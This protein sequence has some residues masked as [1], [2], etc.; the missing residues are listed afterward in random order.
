[1]RRQLTVYSPL[2][3]SG[4]VGAASA[5]AFHGERE[6]RQLERELLRRFSADRVI[7]TG[8]GT[9]A[10]QLAIEATVTHRP[11]RE[12]VVALPG[13]SCFDLVSA[14][15][16]ADVAVRFYDVDPSTLT[17]DV[18]S[19]R[20]ALLGGA[21]A[22]VVG[23]LYGY[24][25]NWSELRAVSEE[26]EVP[27]IEDAAQGLGTTA[28]VGT[29]GTLGDMT[30]LSFG[31]GKG[32]TGGG[33]G[34]VLVRGERRRIDSAERRTPRS[35]RSARAALVTAVVWGLGRPHLYG[36]PTAV[37][38]LGLGETTYSDPTGP[39]QMSSFSA[40]LARR[41]E[42]ASLAAVEGR[43][44]VAERWMRLLRGDVDRRLNVCQPLG[45]TGNAG[46]LRLPLLAQSADV[47]QK[48][49]HST[50]RQG[51]AKGYP[52]P[53]HRL[54]QAAPLIRGTPHD[55]P[56]SVRLS[57]SLVTLPTHRWVSESDMTKIA[58]VIRPRSPQ[59][60]A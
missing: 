14:A 57:E 48:V 8:S 5:A 2:S 12:R 36:I 49:W 52:T 58:D 19:F 26:A 10:L 59:G 16:G 33:G 54:S 31:R 30:V 45:G 20:T 27:V 51:V 47:A 11:P 13:Y 18:S 38:G 25:L 15:V 55:L 29:G 35:G 37:S 9:Q 56:G 40:A 23:N 22:A 3:L 24:P 53:L 42:A 50:R 34:A 43:R 28:D 46:F 17:P 4:I 60:R 41:T 1:M 39:D 6:R 44:V 7:L 21:S 32:W